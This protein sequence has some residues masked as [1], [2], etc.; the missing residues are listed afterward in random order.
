MPGSSFRLVVSAD[1]DRGIAELT[2]LDGAGVQLGYREVDFHSLTVSER[3]ALFD[4]RTYLHLYKPGREAES[5]AETGVLIAEK[6][7]GADLFL[8]LW[9]SRSQRTLC[10]QLPG[11]GEEENPLAAQL[12]RVPWE[13]A[14]PEVGKETL[15]ERNVLVRVVHDAVRPVS[16]PLGPSEDG[17]LR[18]LCVFAEAQGSPPLAAR[19]ERRELKRLFEAEVYPKRK[20]EV[21]F[22]TH[23]VTRERLHEQIQGR[24]GYHVVHWSGHGHLNLLE[25]AKPDGSADRLSGEELLSL[26]TEAGG[27]IPRLVFL[28]ACHSGDILSVESWKD[29]LVAARGA[30]PAVRV[31]ALEEAQGEKKI[32]VPEQPGYTGTAHA[33]LQG[34]V[35]SV[36]AMRYAVGDDY[37]RSLAIE[38]Y[39]ALFAHQR[40]KK[41][42]EALTIARNELLRS[43]EAET[44]FAAADM[45]T[46]VLYGAEDPGLS[47]QTGRSP[48]L[49][50]R[51][52]RLH[53]ISELTVAEHASFV[54]RT[55][56]LA[57]LGASFIGTSESLNVKPFALVTGLGGMGKTA[58]AAEVID[59]WEQR[60]EWV[61]LYQAKPNALAF[62]TTLRDI[63]M[64]LYAE[65]GR[66]H[67]HVQ[68]HPADAIYRDADAAFTGAERTER[69]TR[70]LLQALRDEAILLVLDNFESNLKP[71]PEPGPASEPLWACQDP[72]WDRC[73]ALL[74]TGL[75]GHPS[76]VLL[77]CRKRL[78][79]L[80]GAAA[81]GCHHVPLGPLPPGEAALYLRE[82][83]AL[84]RMVDGP[85]EQERRLALRL[86]S[87]SRFFPLLMDRLAR[88]AAG[89]PVLRPQLL[90]ALAAI[91]TTHD[92]SSLPEL[93]SAKPGDAKELAYLED[94]LAVSLD[95]LIRGASP[96]ARRLLWMIAVANEPVALG[97]VQATWSGSNL[98]PFLAHLVAVG[99]VTEER[100]A[101]DDENP[102]LT[103][104]ELVR[105]R[106]RGWME[107]SDH[108]GDR[109]GLDENTIRLAY[110]ERLEAVFK[111][112]QHQNMTT[113]LEAGRRALVYC[114]QAR[115]WERLGSFASGV[116]TGSKDPV[117]Q[118]SLVPHLQAAAEAAPEG[119]PRWRCLSVLAD[120][121]LEVQPDASVPFYEQAAAQARSATEEVG[122][123]AK[124]AWADLAVTSGNWA[125]ALRYVGDLDSAR[126]RQIESA[127]A[128]R[129]AGSSEIHILGSELEALRIDV[130]ESNPAEA[131][132]EIECRVERLEGWWRRNQAGQPIPEAPDP[133]DLARALI[134][135]LDIAAQAHFAQE[136]R[137]RAL[138]RIDASLEVQRALKRSEVDIGSTR[139]N[140]AGVLG[141]LRRFTE[142]RSELEGCLVIFRND[143]ARYAATLSSLANLF[144]E[145]GDL[146]SAIETERRALAFR[147]QLLDPGERA[148]SHNNLATYLN[149]SGNPADRAEVARH[150]FAALVY[151]L[152]TGLGQ[153]LQTMRQSYAIVFRRAHAEGTEP[154]VPRIAELLADPAFEPLEAW[155]RKRGVDR[156]ELQARV[157]QFLEEARQMALGAGSDGAAAVPASG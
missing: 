65:L 94:A 143:P 53:Q 96:D 157:D 34:G 42:S 78:A 127:E 1:S 39:R 91:E 12:A 149:R 132:L 61:L 80:A 126:R 86:L 40:P 64:K 54:G 139:M 58:L 62:D 5:V 49:D 13:I 3:R 79:A 24:G 156:E 147:E 76:R 119:E 59:L 10:I 142:A 18:V 123:G 95:E 88:L 141:R 33:L 44:R 84:S 106:I 11:A 21:D 19:R 66:Y 107:K 134:S 87:V 151:S 120:A 82:H 97:L 128:H 81:S 8:K 57:G 32:E 112:L 69:L 20:I 121:L 4:L 26:F 102:D 31:V 46:P 111:A 93:F 140:R 144:G 122:D 103:C 47:W 85:D 108:E 110:A 153:H 90:A 16:E 60:F 133:E 98:Q 137:K 9:E 150:Q 89:C 6:I 131:L 129:K 138:H 48:A 92:A 70:N 37:A 28:S 77:T 154:V 74:A 136:D 41:L 109:A 116:V 27:Y 56:E 118:G 30:E 17:C 2:L 100:R 63:H 125:N 68:Q 52:R 35:P 67:Q 36:V 104:H 75:G 83:E 124:Q 45:A 145:Q 7:L 38:M 14:R 25:L 148:A 101:A 117:L 99:L 23:G 73:L 155:L 113:A 29:F 72:A 130:N 55:W 152:P 114:V 115:A 146:Q 71:S 43:P 15:A 50:T 105:E 51:N 135:A 22:L